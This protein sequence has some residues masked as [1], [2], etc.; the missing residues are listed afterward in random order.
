MSTLHLHC[1]YLTRSELY[2][3]GQFVATAR[4][5]REVPVADIAE[6][7]KGSTCEECKRLTPRINGE[8]K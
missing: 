3:V 2:G 4:C 7:L 5:G 1:F 8:M 6:T